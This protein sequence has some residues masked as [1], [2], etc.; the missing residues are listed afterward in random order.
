MSVPIVI[1]SPNGELDL[2]VQSAIAALGE[3]VVLHVEERKSYHEDQE[4]NRC[5]NIAKARTAAAKK[6]LEDYPE[7]EYLFFLD[8]DV[9][10][11]AD[12]IR[13]L[14]EWTLKPLAVGGWFPARNGDKWVGGRWV[15]DHTFELFN[16]VHRRSRLTETHLLS[17]GCTL[18]SRELVEWHCFDPGIDVYCRNKAGDEFIVA[19]SGAFSE[20]LIQKNVRMFLDA[21]VVC[22]HLSV[23]QQIKY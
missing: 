8:S 12:A 4:K 15:A 21:A 5:I 23:G 19:D 20:C 17:L 1:I 10:P 18:L 6:A 2:K 16:C 9:V 22:E 11:P 3:P 13:R 14:G 7:A